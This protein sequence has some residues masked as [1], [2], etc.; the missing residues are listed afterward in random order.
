MTLQQQRLRSSGSLTGFLLIA[1][2]VFLLY[3]N[4]TGAISAV[5]GHGTSRVVPGILLALANLQQSAGERPLHYLLQRA[6]VSLWPIVLVAAGS[7]L[8]ALL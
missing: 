2:G 1:V 3:E 7:L 8:A 6:L 5:T 4:A